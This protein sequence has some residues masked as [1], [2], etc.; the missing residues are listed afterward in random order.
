MHRYVLP[1]LDHCRYS[2][3]RMGVRGTA[4]AFPSDRFPKLSPNECTLDHTEEFI[5]FGRFL[6][7]Q[8]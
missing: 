3:L 8:E 4:L 2:I 6:I 7:G 5:S 1:M